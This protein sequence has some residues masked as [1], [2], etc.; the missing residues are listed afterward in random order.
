MHALRC[1]LSLVSLVIG[2]E[3]FW[4]ECINPYMTS[5]CT[6]WQSA[7]SVTCF[8]LFFWGGGNNCVGVNVCGGGWC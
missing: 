8:G 5:F 3:F 2:E 6:S 7:F 1:A 4:W